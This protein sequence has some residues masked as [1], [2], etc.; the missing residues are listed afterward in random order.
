MGLV[1]I[2]ERVLALG[3]RMELTSDHG[4]V[5]HVLL[6]LPASGELPGSPATP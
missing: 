2:R 1:G 3:G 4:T 5:L 6:P